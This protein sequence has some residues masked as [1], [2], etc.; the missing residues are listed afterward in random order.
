MLTPCGANQKA[1]KRTIALGILAG[2]F[3]FLFGLMWVGAYRYLSNLNSGIETNVGNSFDI[4]D[5]DSVLPIDYEKEKL[6]DPKED[7]TNEAMFDPAGYYYFD[8]E[9]ANFD[10][11]YYIVINNSNIHDPVEP[12]GKNH[13]SKLSGF[14]LLQNAEKVDYLDFES[15]K[16][17]DGKLS[18]ATKVREGISYTFEGVF[19]IKG[20]FYTLDPDQKLLKGNLF[21]NRN[22]QTVAFINTTFKWNL[23]IGCLH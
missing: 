18:F 22:R 15:I 11:F 7:E 23:D 14:V 4:N 16:I 1:M 10:D 17:E 12:S 20:N 21:K 6:S 9:P 19:L 3:T 8:E 13:T 5:P 2:T